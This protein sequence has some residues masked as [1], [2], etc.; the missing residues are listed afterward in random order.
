MQLALAVSGE[1]AFFD[2]RVYDALRGSTVVFEQRS[3]TIAGRGAIALDIDGAPAGFP[4]DLLAEYALTLSSVMTTS[5]N[6][7][8]NNSATEHLLALGAYYSGRPDLQLGGTA[9]TLLGQ[10]PLV[11]ADS[12]LSGKP[13]DVGVLLVFRYI[14]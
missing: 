4:V 5:A 14:W 6:E 1:T 7:S 12:S 11:A 13:Q 10:V 2:P 3:D 8:S 9:Y